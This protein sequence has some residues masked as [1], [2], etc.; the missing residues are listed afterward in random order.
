ML[1][2]CR[3]HLTQTCLHTA[4]KVALWDTCSGLG[5]CSVACIVFQFGYLFH[6]SGRDV[7]SDFHAVQTCPVQC[8][9][10]GVVLP[11]CDIL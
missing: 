2:Q 9:L 1:L 10:V 5:V 8:V 7:Y 3:V 4:C 6:G 11:Q